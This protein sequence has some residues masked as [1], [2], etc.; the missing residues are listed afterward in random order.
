M[1]A[2]KLEQM[3]V[4]GLKLALKSEQMSVLERMSVLKLASNLELMLALKSASN[5][6]PMSGLRWE[7]SMGKKPVLTV[8]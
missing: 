3:L 4:S 7:Q 6:E 1:L 8:V 2:L 5:L